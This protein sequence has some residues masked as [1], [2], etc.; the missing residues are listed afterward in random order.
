[1]TQSPIVDRLMRLMSIKSDSNTIHERK[2]S[3]FLV[4][5]IA[6]NPYYQTHPEHFGTFKLNGDALEREV[7]WAFCDN[8][9]AKTVILLS[10]YDVVT[11]ANENAKKTASDTWV[12]GRGAS[13]MKSG[14]AVHLHLL[15]SVRS[16]TNLLLVSVPDQ[17]GFSE[18]ARQALPFLNALKAKF[19]LTYELVIGS[20]PQIG[21]EETPFKIQ[22]GSVGKMQPFVFVKGTPVHSGCPFSGLNAIA[23]TMEI[24]KAIDQNTEMS[25]RTVGQMTPPPTFLTIKDLKA[26]YDVTTP[27]YA[28]GLFN[29]LFLKDDMH[30][31]FEQLKELC[32]W[33]AE[34]AVNQYNYSYN[35]YLKKQKLPSYRECQDIAVEVIFYG[36]LCEMAL[37]K[38]IEIPSELESIEMVRCLVEQLA[39]ENPLVVIGLLP[40]LYPPVAHETYDSS[41]LKALLESDE[42]L[43]VEPYYMQISDLSYFSA[44]SDA[45]IDVLKHMPKGHEGYLETF[46]EAAALNLPVINIGPRSRGMHTPSESVYKY[47]VETLLPNLIKKIIESI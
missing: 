40:P 27:E 15:E 47:D 38:G 7:V 5:E 9:H 33:S 14:L 11:L 16:G 25:D 4:S 46:N 44:V 28:V 21:S 42:A 2:F 1:M 29:W 20:E 39:F 37:A 13:D 36:E 6:Q 23:L 32:V 35:E 26:H 34:D 43:A 22:T 8:G 19:D 30:K 45:F 18:G 31:K 24:I 41:T 17:E 3:D 12:Y 10:H